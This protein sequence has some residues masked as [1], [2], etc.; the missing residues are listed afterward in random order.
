MLGNLFAQPLSKLSLVYLL[1]WSPLPP[2][3]YWYW[4]I[5]MT[6]QMRPQRSVKKQKNGSVQA[7]RCK[8]RESCVNSFVHFSCRKSSALGRE[9][10]GVSGCDVDVIEA[11][12]SN[13]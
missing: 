12:D 4:K 2:T 10:P 1:V 5:L 13:S 9:L 11:D 3:P 7:E 8:T 6:M